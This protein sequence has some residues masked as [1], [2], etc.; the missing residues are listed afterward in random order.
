MKSVVVAPPAYPREGD[1]TFAN[2]ADINLIGVSTLYH[3]EVRRFFKVFGQTLLA[4]VITTLVFLAV[5]ALAL[6]G[7]A[8]HIGELSFLEFLVPGLVMMGITQNAFANTSSSLMI[9]KI[10]GTIIDYLMPPLRPAEL[11]VGISMGG[12][13]R[14]VLVGAVITIAALVFVRLPMSHPWLILYFFLVSSLMLSLL[15]MLAALWAEKFDQM[16]M[17]TN[18]VITPLSFLSGTFYSINDLPYGFHLAALANPFFYMIDGLRFAMSGHADGNVW[19][20]ALVV[21]LVDIL[22]WWLT[23]RFFRTGHRLKA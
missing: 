16:A 1:R 19:V 18:F 20:G 13:T 6:G 8:R 21:L 12:V 5:F 14:G 17:V 10:Q 11:V 23:L 9:A 22:L 3:K 2:F 4:P 15:G 7:N